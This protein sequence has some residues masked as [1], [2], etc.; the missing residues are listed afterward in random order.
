MSAKRVAID[1]GASSGRVAVGELCDGK[2]CFEI[3]H[4]FQN[5][6]IDT[7]DGLKWDFEGLIRE[8][9]CGLVLA[10]K[11]GDIAS[12]GVD[13][14]A[15]D[16][17]IVNQSGDTV[18]TP[19]HYR[20]SRTNGLMESMLATSGDLIF[21][22]TGL[23]F[24][25]FNTLYQ[26]KAHLR[27]VPDDFEPGS[28]ILMVPDLIHWHL[29]GGEGVRGI[30][31]TNAS[32]TQFYDPQSKQWSAAM[33]D[34]IPLDERFLPSLIEPGA[35]LGRL[36]P[37]LA[38]H[39]GLAETVVVAPATHDTASA[40][41]ATP[42]KS[43]DRD[44]YVSSGTWSLVGMELSQPVL[45]PSAR[46]LN[47]SNEVG[48]FGTVRFLKNVMGLW[49]LQECAR[50]WGLNDFGALV[51]QSIDYVD[52]AVTFDPDD[53]VFLESGLDMPLRVMNALGIQ[54]GSE[55]DTPAYL[56]GAILASLA[57]K[58]VAVARQ[59]LELNLESGEGGGDGHSRLARINIVGGGSQN[60]V[61]NQL[62]AD[63]AGC[64][65][66]AGPVEATLM[67][68]FLMQFHAAGDLGTDT[69]RQVIERSCEVVSYQ[70]RAMT[71]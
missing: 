66:V 44:V 12:V 60:Q 52:L 18:C 70:P 65:V 17:G 46:D 22:E 61:L 10:G 39:S 6:G 47:F 54:P 45:T 3:V 53:R 62:I 71:P 21:S 43:P 49:I 41:L 15:V 29:M 13:S 34:L 59:A 51:T 9:E 31:R 26:L 42:L 1:L 30:E 19:Y 16:Y 23:Q 69:I 25:P 40:I 14:W 4:R 7:D 33:L 32:T 36:A 57:V 5:G 67:G 48:A 11:L 2:L 63:V 20:N 64:E 27:D 8:I 68:N 58:T 28:Q 37:S 35:V 55:K 38:R 56:T 50:S 24:L